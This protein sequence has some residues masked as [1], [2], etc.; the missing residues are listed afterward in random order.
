MFFFIDLLR[1]I[2]Y[3]DLNF[4][5]FMWKRFSLEQILLIFMAI[6]IQVAYA[7]NE[8]PILPGSTIMYSEDSIPGAVSFDIVVADTAQGLVVFSSS[9][10]KLKRLNRSFRAKAELPENSSFDRVLVRRHG[11]ST[12]QVY[13]LLTTKAGEGYTTAGER[14]NLNS[15]LETSFGI[16]RGETYLKA[17]ERANKILED[18]FLARDPKY[19]AGFRW[20]SGRPIDESFLDFQP[21]I[22]RFLNDTDANGKS[23]RGA[24]NCALK[25]K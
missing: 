13:K 22:E 18:K 16:L 17:I 12:Y 8:S 19:F 5:G 1:N 6:G 7:A 23:C 24:C 21:D 15:P 14:F 2:A 20:N 11:Q 9:S 10:G 25:S 4:G 3:I